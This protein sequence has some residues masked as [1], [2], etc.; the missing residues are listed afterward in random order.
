MDFTNEFRI[1]AH[2][3]LILYFKILQYVSD[4]DEV[5]LEDELQRIRLLFEQG[6]SSVKEA[7]LATGIVCGVYGHE[8]R[9]GR[10]KG[11]TGGKFQVDKLILATPPALPSP[12]K[13]IQMKDR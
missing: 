5:V 6:E 4:T 13:P 11:T 12:E 3:F 2:R 8:I 9:T 7:D 10:G 1:H